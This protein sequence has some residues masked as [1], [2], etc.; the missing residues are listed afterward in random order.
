V[1]GNEVTLYSGMQDNGQ[2]HT[3]T[4]VQLLSQKLGI[5]ARGR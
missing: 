5:D 4:F 1:A 2:G 3:T